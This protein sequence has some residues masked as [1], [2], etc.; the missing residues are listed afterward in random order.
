VQNLFPILCTTTPEEGPTARNIFNFIAAAVGTVWL[1]LTPYLMLG[2]A[3]LYLPAL[4]MTPMPEWIPIYW[5]MVAL[6]CFQ[7]VLQFVTLVRLLPSRPARIV[8]LILKCWGLKIGVVLLLKYPNYV[9]T[10]YPEIN[11]W[12]NLSFLIS[13]IV[14]IGITLFGIARQLLRLRPEAGAVNYAR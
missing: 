12:A 5:E 1:A 10:P 8:D 13:V 11:V 9:S 7:L 14:A 2:P 3:A 4:H 6:L